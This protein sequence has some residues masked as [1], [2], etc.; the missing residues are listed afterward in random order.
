[1]LKEL[2]EEAQWFLKNIEGLNGDFSKEIGMSIALKIFPFSPFQIHLASP[3][4]YQNW[5]Q[6]FIKEDFEK[7]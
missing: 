3:E 6:K 2:S 1:M 4:E 5:Y 7:I